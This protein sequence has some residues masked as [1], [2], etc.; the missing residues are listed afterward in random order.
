M[1]T[2]RKG[3]IFLFLPLFLSACEQRVGL[4]PV[5]ELNWETARN[6]NSSHPLRHVV[7][8]G[9]TL[10]AIA[11]RYDQDYR[12]LAAINNLSSPYT[13]RVGQVLRVQPSIN[14]P[15]RPLQETQRF[16]PA[17]PP[18]ARRPL[19]ARSAPIKY[20]PMPQPKA[21]IKKQEPAA[22]HQNV[23]SNSQWQWPVYGKI[24]TG[25]VPQ[26]GKKGID[27]AGKK[28]EKIHAAASGV[29]AYAGSGL[30]GYGNLI[31]IKHNNQ[32]LTAYGNNWRNLV[33]E[34][35]QVKAGQVIAEMGLIDN[36]FWGLHF[37]I[38]KAGQPVNPLQYLK[39]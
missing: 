18:V 13:L 20:L 34:G 14:Q 15:I 22:T 21:V 26:Q 9:E 25:F 4:A 1:C 19:P 12:Q 33:R 31:I 30:A 2:V 23:A 39:K 11:F 6:R 16:I 7:V 10:Y 38:R 8:R 32:F 36:R 24:M 5:V 3:I 28:G 27:I 29:V 35:Q 17:P 37:E